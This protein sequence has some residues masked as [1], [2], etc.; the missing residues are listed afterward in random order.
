MPF[1]GNITDRK[2]QFTYDKIYS[3]YNNLLTITP[4]PDAVPGDKNIISISPSQNDGVMI[5]RYILIDYSQDENNSTNNKNNDIA[6]YGRSWDSTVWQKIY[7]SGVFKY[8]LIADFNETVNEEL[9]AVLFG[10]NNILDYKT[11]IQSQIGHI[12][13]RK[14]PGENYDKYEYIK[15]TGE[16]F[17]GNEIAFFNTEAQSLI[18]LAAGL[19]I[20][21]SEAQINDILQFWPSKPFSA[22]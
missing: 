16:V 15:G 21:I 8:I 13:R 5:G 19:G 9:E 17:T 2:N 12:Y 10:S 11:D 20:S 18:A 6:K 14:T 1:Y 4:N 22:N 7:E 3:S